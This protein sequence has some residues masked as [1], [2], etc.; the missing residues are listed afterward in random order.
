M[1]TN[2]ECSSNAKATLILS[3]YYSFGIPSILYTGTLV[4]H[5]GG[6]WEAIQSSGTGDIENVYSLGNSYEGYS[7]PINAFANERA[8]NTIDGEGIICALSHTENCPMFNDTGGD[9]LTYPNILYNT[10]NYGV[11]CPEYNVV[12][13][14]IAL[15][16]GEYEYNNDST[17]NNIFKYISTNVYEGDNISCMAICYNASTNA[18]E[19]ELEA[20]MVY[21]GYVI[22]T[23]TTTG[24]GTTTTGGGTTTT[25]GIGGEGTGTIT[26]L[27]VS[28]TNTAPGY[29][30]LP[31]LNGG[32]LP[33]G[34]IGNITGLGSNILGLSTAFLL[35]L[36]VLLFILTILLIASEN[37]PMGCSLGALATDFFV[38][39]LPWLGVMPVSLLLTINFLAVSSFFIR[40]RDG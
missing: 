16:I 17:N 33:P 36:I 6:W 23:T 37:L 35:Q 18:F 14:S 25:S 8:Y 38:L 1:F 24:G 12:N 19:Y 7:S 2:P 39:V 10:C 34:G 32:A 40:R 11:M 9:M 3:S 21:G 27:W 5:N 22:P 31:G 4:L 30:T 29:G 15:Y 26:N 13:C 20:D 28:P